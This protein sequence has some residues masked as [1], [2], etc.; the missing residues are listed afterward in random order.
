MSLCSFGMLNPPLA[1][2]LP[3]R[4]VQLLGGQR[5]TMASIYALF[6][7][8]T[9]IGADDIALQ[10]VELNIDPDME[11]LEAERIL[12]KV[13]SRKPDGLKMEE[14]GMIDNSQRSELPVTD[15]L[16][17]AL[18][19]AELKESKGINVIWRDMADTLGL[20]RTQ[21]YQW[22]RVIDTRSD[23]WVKKVVD[24]VLNHNQPFQKLA[25]IAAA[26]QT[27]RE[28]LYQDWYDNRPV[29]DK[30]KKVSLGVTSNMPALRRLILAN[31]SSKAK[32]QF[33]NVDWDNPKLVKKAFAD[34]LNLWE[35]EHG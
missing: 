15:R 19:Y 30:H 20:N 10:R 29:P 35:E 25:D 1:Y 3:G 8:E 2:A 22:L 6:H 31:V 4:E 14:V 32:Y 12:V 34:F 11:M 5:R 23:P 21:A 33:D 18:K 28:A 16:R 26:D 24:K 7:I 27:D 9:T 13:Y 17:W